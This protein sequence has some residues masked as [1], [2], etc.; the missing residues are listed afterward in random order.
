MFQNA[1]MSNYVLQ[2]SGHIYT[3]NIAGTP[4]AIITVTILLHDVLMSEK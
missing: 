1:R 3:L 2:C 4:N